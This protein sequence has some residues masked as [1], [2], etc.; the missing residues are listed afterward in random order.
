LQGG[1]HAPGLQHLP[2]NVLNNGDRLGPV[3]LNKKCRNIY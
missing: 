2:L 1:W 3:I